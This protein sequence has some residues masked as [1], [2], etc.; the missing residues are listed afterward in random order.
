[1]DSIWSW[2]NSC[3]PQIFLLTMWPEGHYLT[4]VYLDFLKC[5]I[6]SIVNQRNS[7]KPWCPEFLLQVQC[8][9]IKHLCDWLQLL[10]LNP[11][12]PTPAKSTKQ[13][14]AINHTVSLN[15]WPSW[16]YAAQGLRH[17]KILFI[18]Q[19]IFKGSE[20]IS[21]ELAKRQSWRYTFFWGMGR[22]RTTQTCRVNTFLHKPPD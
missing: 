10:R 2:T 5:V 11:P 17:T 6:W 15:T 14:F 18:R 19:N 4:F 12:A 9:T 3:Q 16:Y 13:G 21:Q 1:M 20:F 7:P 22:V 8:L